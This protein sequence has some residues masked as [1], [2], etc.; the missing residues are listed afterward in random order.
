MI[1]IFEKMLL[2]N[3]DIQYWLDKSRKGYPCVVKILRCVHSCD[4]DGIDATSQNIIS[5][6]VDGMIKVR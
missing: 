6:S 5:G 4:I 3:G 1:K 2:S